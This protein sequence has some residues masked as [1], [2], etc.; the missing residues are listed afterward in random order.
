MDKA[1]R[2]MV[3]FLQAA[4]SIPLIVLPIS[5]CDRVGRNPS[6]K[7]AIQELNPNHPTLAH[8]ED[9]NTLP[10]VVSLSGHPS[11]CSQLYHDQ[12]L[13]C[14]VAYSCRQKEVK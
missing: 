5:Y 9:G 11:D 7:V 10:S 13:S 3:G 6:T 4:Y 2:V 14:E 1:H 12:V 8:L